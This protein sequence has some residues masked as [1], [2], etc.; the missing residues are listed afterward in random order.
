MCYLVK[1]ISSRSSGPAPPRGNGSGAS[2]HP[3]PILSRFLLPSTPRLQ[4]GV[5]SWPP[6]HLASSYWRADCHLN[7]MSLF[8]RAAAPPRH[9]AR[10][11]V[12]G[13][14]AMGT[15]RSSKEKAAKSR[16]GVGR[17]YTGPPGHDD[18]CAERWD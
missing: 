17:P 10:E 8:D 1:W 11:A 7:A 13:P 3:L 12:E 14:G 16:E 5:I 15:H 18:R 2:S 6:I 9:Y 4:Q